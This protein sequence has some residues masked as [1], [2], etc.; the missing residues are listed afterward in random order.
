MNLLDMPDKCVVT[1]MPQCLIETSA[2]EWLFKKITLIIT[3][4][5]QEVAVE[6]HLWYNH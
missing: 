2:G 5:A 1:D 4:Y 6:N 3:S